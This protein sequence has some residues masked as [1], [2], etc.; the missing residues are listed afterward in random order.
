MLILNLYSSIKLR[1][2]SF[3]NSL[4]QVVYVANFIQW[5]KFNIFFFCK[6]IHLQT[7]DTLQFLVFDRQYILN[8]LGPRLCLKTCN[9]LSD[10]LM[11]RPLLSNP[12]PQINLGTLRLVKII[13]S[14]ENTTKS[15]GLVF[16]VEIPEY[17]IVSEPLFLGKSKVLSNWRMSA[18]FKVVV[19]AKVIV[20]LH[21]GLCFTLGHIHECWCS[22][23]FRV[24]GGQR[25]EG[26]ESHLMGVVSVVLFHPF[27]VFER[28]LVH[29]DRFVVQSIVR[30]FIL[31]M[32]ESLSVLKLK[33]KSLQRFLA[34]YCGI[35]VFPLGFRWAWLFLL[36][37]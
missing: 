8:A 13:E 2:C 1:L 5:R 22:P 6:F 34:N 29:L 11:E 12:W 30:V 24:H 16:I 7:C 18:F 25:V 17:S 35:L 9:I 4:R 31:D 26:D 23:H 32:S 36:Y 14:F 28:L 10:I 19:I 3:F 27:W 15:L 20:F 33:S 21:L 37:R